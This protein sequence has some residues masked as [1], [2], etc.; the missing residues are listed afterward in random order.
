[1]YMNNSV[2]KNTSQYKLNK[3]IL[4]LN[5]YICNHKNKFNKEIGGVIKEIRIK[6]NISLDE[7]SIHTFMSPIY[8][9]QIEKGINGISLNKFVLICNSLK[10]ESKEILDDFLYYQNDYDLLFEE[11]QQYK[12]LSQTV[13]EFMKKKK[14]VYK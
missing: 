12:N 3:E 10:I 6:K 13:I 14:I 11:L 5:Q 1:M 8:L 9:S 7:M 2:E 4:Y